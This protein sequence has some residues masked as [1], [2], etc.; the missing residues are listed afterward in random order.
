VCIRN[1]LSR[2]LEPRMSVRVVVVV[3]LSAAHAIEIVPHCY[4]TFFGRK[5]PWKCIYKIT[6]IV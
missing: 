3:V 6:H 4:F 1:T 5:M 2:E